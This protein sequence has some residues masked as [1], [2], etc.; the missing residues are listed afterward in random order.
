MLF[1]PCPRCH[2][3][4]WGPV[5]TL[6]DTLRTP[7]TAGGR[8]VSVSPEVLGFIH[9]IPSRLISLSPEASCSASLGSWPMPSASAPTLRCPLLGSAIAVPCH[10]PEGRAIPPGTFRYLTSNIL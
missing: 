9:P 7:R 2:P 5:H 10:R 3:G 1:S 8:S 4:P 6:P